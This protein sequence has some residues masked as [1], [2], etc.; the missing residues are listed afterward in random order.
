VYGGVTSTTVDNG[1]VEILFT[2]GTAA[3]STINNGGELLLSG[4]TATDTTLINGG[5]II[6][7]TLTYATGLTGTITGGTLVVDNAGGTQVFSL[8]LDGDYSTDVLQVTEATDGK[9]ELTLCFYPGTGIATPDGTTAVE[10][11]RPGDLVLTANGPLPV[12]WVG[13]SHIATRFADK[14]R[15][16]P[17]RITAGALGNGLPLRDLLLSPDHAVFLG[18]ILAQAS[19][20]VND[21]TILREYDVPAQF[22]YHHVELATHELLLAEGVQ[23]ESFVDNVDR[24]HFHNWDERTAPATPIA[25]MPYPRAKAQRQLPPAVRRML[26]VAKQA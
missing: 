6:A 7:E 22:T 13:Q 14:Q 3:F 17:V 2:G 8:Q 24:M 18:G 5:T 11:L 9:T 26:A 25:E 21:V 20:L 12:R 23:A 15:S 16:L 10:D 4:G 19:A 1:G